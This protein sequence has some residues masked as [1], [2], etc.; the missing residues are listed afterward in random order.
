MSVVGESTHHSNFINRFIWS[1]ASRFGGKSKEVERFLKFLVV[2]TIGAII[3][4]GTLNLLQSTILSPSGAHEV[5]HVRLATSTAF[6]AAVTSNFIW[7]RYWTY[8]DSRSRPI[9]LQLVQFFIVNITAVAFRVVLV[10]LSYGLLGDLA[11]EVARN[12]GWDDATVN[13][14][15]TNLAQTLSMGIALFWNF[16]VNRYWTYGDVD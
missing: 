12:P 14:I 7:N 13:Q 1:V 10:S 11:Y 2:G 5:I 16:F 6:T 8:P 9:T 4:L 3:D 15:G